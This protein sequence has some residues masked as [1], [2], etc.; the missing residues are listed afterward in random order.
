VSAVKAM[1]RVIQYLRAHPQLPA[2]V[3][4]EKGGENEL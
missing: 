1:K 3:K 4:W 2:R